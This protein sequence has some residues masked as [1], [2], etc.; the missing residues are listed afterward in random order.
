MN[1]N[2]LKLLQIT[3]LAA[4]FLLSFQLFLKDAKDGL[5]NAL[6]AS[7]KPLPPF[8]LTDTEGQKITLESFRGKVVL[9]FFGYGNCP[10]I[11]PM[12]LKRYM[13][14][15]KLL[16]EHA[17]S[18]SMLFIT[19]DPY[20]DSPQ[21]LKQFVSRYS[22]N[23][24]ALTGTWDELA[25]VWQRYLVRPLD[26]GGQSAYIAH[27]AVIYVGDRNLVLRKIFTPE[28]SAEAIA[29]EIVKLLKHS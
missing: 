12:A 23:I 24:V 20:R 26:D 3:A 15:E 5:D 11:C 6:L 14:V 19:T 13:E 22:P 7:G 1:K 4:I 29:S 27:S 2:I 8:T 28:M 17:S 10:D 18:V 16:G 9:I 25:D 21:S